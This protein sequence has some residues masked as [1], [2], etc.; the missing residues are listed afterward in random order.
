M[1]TA[2][3]ADQTREFKETLHNLR[4]AG[5]KK[6][7]VSDVLTALD[8]PI[9]KTLKIYYQAETDW[10]RDFLLR[11]VFPPAECVFFRAH[12]R[13]QVTADYKYPHRA[14]VFSSNWLSVDDVKRMC[15]SL[16]PTIIVHCSDEYGD[17]LAYEEL[18][19]M[20]QLYLR[21]YFY[22]HYPTR[23][24]TVV[25]PLG[26]T[27]GMFSGSSFFHTCKPAAERELAWAHVGA[28]KAD[29]AEMQRAF[30]S[31][32]P[33]FFG[34]SDKAVM[35]ALYS[36]AK[37]SPIGRGNS[38][39]NC[40]RIYEAIT[41][42]AVPVV[43]ASAQEVQNTFAPDGTLPWLAAE[44]WDDAVLRCRQLVNNNTA[45]DMLQK[46]CTAWWHERV[47]NLNNRVAAVLMQ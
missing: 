14:L 21:Q 42:G 12:E 7:A 9:F 38:S 19:D 34:K 31:L 41:C 36:N 13:E 44:T 33:G 25:I 32:Q 40:F 30:S 47:R 46:S 1:T 2:I 3:T 26:Y 10:E 37:F 15:D 17:R 16:K 20:C 23:A 4:W 35:R 45:I 6:T 18:S 5:V 27:S 39:V 24:N 43:V 11:D 22:A 8:N 28:M 29:R